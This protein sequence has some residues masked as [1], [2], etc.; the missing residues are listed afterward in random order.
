MAGWLLAFLTMVAI[1]VQS[2]LG[3]VNDDKKDYDLDW[4][5]NLV[6]APIIALILVILVGANGLN[7]V[8]SAGL[9]KNVNASMKS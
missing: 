1:I 9:A 8:V 5:C 3:V 7:I 2:I 6:D 4:A